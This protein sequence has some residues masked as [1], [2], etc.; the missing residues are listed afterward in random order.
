MAQ[1][2]TDRIGWGPRVR[3]CADEHPDPQD[4]WVIDQATAT[5]TSYGWV[6]GDF[7]GTF[8]P[9]PQ[10]SCAAYH[11]FLATVA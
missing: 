4:Q 2:Q 6:L 10:E 7:E 3:V 11:Q 5:A 8:G 9:R 1:E